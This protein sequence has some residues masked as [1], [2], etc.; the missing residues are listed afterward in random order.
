M[1]A[2]QKK[3]SL[4]K[5]LV[6]VCSVPVFLVGMFFLLRELLFPKAY[7]GLVSQYSES[8][9]IPQSFVY[10]VINTE[11][12]F[13]SSAQSDV[14]ARGLMQI[15]EDAFKWTKKHL[16]A[17]HTDISYDDLYIPEYNIEYGCCMLSYYY[18]K[19]DSLGLSAAAY[20]AG[21][22]KVDEWISD[23]IISTD[24]FDADDIPSDATAHYVNKVMRAYWAYE[25]LYQQE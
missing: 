12:G 19:Y 13:D 17:V 9:G 24:D 7:E 3:G 14:G 22:N 10:A 2:K 4:L 6:F 5:R 8:Y 20:H 11:S 21:T 16:D 1:S 15:M 18:K 23:G 25:N